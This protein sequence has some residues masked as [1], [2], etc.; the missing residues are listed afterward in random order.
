[1]FYKTY[2]K[3]PLSVDVSNL[4]DVDGLKGCIPE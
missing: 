3:Y 4:E 2:M 1:M